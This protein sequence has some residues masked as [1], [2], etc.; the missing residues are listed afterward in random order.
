[1]PSNTDRVLFLGLDGATMSAL[2]PLFDRGWMPALAGH[3]R[4]SATGT[5]RSTTPMVTPVAWSSFATGMT[6]KSHGVMDFQ[7]LDPAD[8]TI[9]PNHAGRLRAP[10]LWEIL[11][12]HGRSVV[13]LNLPM[14]WPCRAARGIVVAGADAPGR[15]SAFAECPDFEAELAAEI[16]AYSHKLLW[17]SRPRTLDAL[18]AEVD[19]TVA[20]FAAQAEA[21]IRA[22]ARVE[23]SALMVHFHN[24][25]GIQHRLWPYLDL[26]ETAAGEPAWTAE[27]ARAYRALD[28]AAGRL[29]ELAD[30]R[31][32]AVV[33][34]S[35]H[36]F[37]PCRALVDVNGLLRAAG[38]Q[39][40]LP[41]GTRFRYRLN[42]VA[43]RLRRH[44]TRLGGEQAR[45]PRSIAGLVGCDWRRT[46]AFAPYGQLCA[47]VYL[48]EPVAGPGA[49]DDDLGLLRTA[50]DP[51]TNDLLFADAFAVAERFDLDPAALGLPAVMA[52]SADGYQA[53]AK[54]DPAHRSPLSPDW[55][56]PATHRMAG[57]IAVDAPGA[58]PGPHLVAE[59]HEVAPT[60][61]AIL[62][63]PV[64]GSMEGAPI[65]L[66]PR[67]P[68]RAAEWGR[69]APS[70]TPL[71]V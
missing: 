22:D 50:R 35:D 33:A 16:P 67:Q 56:L 38:L 49:I 11:A 29:L 28:A 30:L 63:L 41:Y 20:A 9:R 71:R 13:S 18:R 2:G 32:A 62:G 57:V 45:A 64:P 1:M 34:A 24:L 66:A 37:G 69:P 70:R 23:W 8:N 31:G 68:S 17:K 19:R 61:L 53:Q 4:R 59:L 43:D 12:G 58:R 26:D 14:T 42:R 60:A 39:R 65:D 15:A 36:G 7:Y 5:L 44:R 47:H 52:P 25:D 3:W 40:G 10:H 54:W 27:V 51:A 46:A 48:N 55:D 21:A 6:P